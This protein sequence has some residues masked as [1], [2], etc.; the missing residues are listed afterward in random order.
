M[1]SIQQSNVRHRNQLSRIPT[2][3]NDLPAEELA[4][5][6]SRSLR[7][8]QRMGL[9]SAETQFLASEAANE[10]RLQQIQQTPVANLTWGQMNQLGKSAPEL[11]AAKWDEAKELALQERR[12]GHHAA[13]MVEGLNSTP[14]ERARFIVLVE[15][16]ER[17]Y[18]PH[19]GMEDVLVQ[20]L[21][22]AQVG[23]EQ[24]LSTLN[25]LT[26]SQCKPP[27]D[28]PD[29][30]EPPRLTEAQ[31]IEQ[32]A[33][34]TERFHRLFIRTLRAIRDL[35]RQPIIVAGQVNIAEQ[36]VVSQSN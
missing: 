35:R 33:Q 5:A 23:Y 11:A 27:I 12:S 26:T 30:W 15:A 21:A 18:E 7:R 13:R 1:K 24:W 28:E 9:S 32:A 29:A 17:Q 14:L 4:R 6:Q 34:M 8:Q 36:Q 20:N 19:N 22:Q 10:A 2:A 3:T 25:R 31:A 16:L